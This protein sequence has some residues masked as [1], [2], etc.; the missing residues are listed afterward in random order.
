MRVLN[1]RKNTSKI[2]ILEQWDSFMLGKKTILLVNFGGPRSLDE[3]EPFLKALLTD[4]EVIRTRMPQFIHNIIFSSAAKKRAKVVKHDYA[5]I[6]GKSPI[7]E[8]TEAIAKRLSEI[9]GFSTLTF[10]RYIPETHPEFIAAMSKVEGEILVFPM[11][12][13]FSYATTGSIAKW[14]WDH[15]PRKIHDQLKWVRSFCSHKAFVSCTQKSI[16]EFLETSSLKEEESMLLFS[17]HGL[18]QSFID[19]GDIYQS[20]CELSAQEIAKGFP[21]MRSL[22]AYQSK[23][24]RGKWLEPSTSDI[25]K[26]ILAHNENRKNI[27][28]VPLSFTSDHIETLF[29]VE[30]LYLPL[31]KEKGLHPFRLPAL[32]RREDWIESIAQI[33]QE[34]FFSETQNLLRH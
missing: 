21:K 3:V 9:T 27:I 31:I 14:F 1:L 20:E 13:Q 32:N 29:E 33:L 7:F 19:T 30:K 25:C 28:F 5:E 2:K 6:G 34:G 15:L 26:E 10:H 8:D 17:A 12:P 22:L 24:G 16:R 23:F 4:K 11:F 18:P